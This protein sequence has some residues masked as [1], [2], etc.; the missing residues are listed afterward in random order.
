MT[1]YNDTLT[2]DLQASMTHLQQQLVTLL[3]DITVDDSTFADQIVQA[4]E[5]ISASSVFAS[6][7][8]QFHVTTSELVDVADLVSVLWKN[9][10]LE[11]IGQSSSVQESIRRIQLVSEL[12]QIYDSGL[13]TGVLTCC[14]CSYPGTS[15][16]PEY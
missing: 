2:E 13:S 9:T 4:L 11:N 15:G 10:I 16:L 3:L 5:T 7:G 1:V 12:V 6:L 8:S 14:H